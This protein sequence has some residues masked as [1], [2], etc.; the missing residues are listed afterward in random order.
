MAPTAQE[1]PSA[2]SDTAG[3]LLKNTA[4]RSNQDFTLEYIKA[5]TNIAD[6]Q[7]CLRQLELEETQVDSDLDDLLAERETLEASLDKLEVLEPQLGSLQNESKSLVK[8][9]SDTSGL[10]EGISAKVRQLDLEQSRVQ[11]A[12]KHVEDIQELKFCISGVQRAME[13]ADYE[14]AARHM[15]KA[16]GFDKTILE[17]SFAE[18][19]VPS[20]SNPE[21]P[22]VMLANAK[23]KLMEIISTEFESAVQRQSEEDI[24]RYFK[25]FPL[26]GEEQVGL[27]K[28]S[29]FVC[30]IVSGKAQASL[31]VPPKSPTFYADTLIRLF[32]SIA[33]II[34]QHQPVVEK[35]Y[36]PGK[37][38]R[39]I[40]RLQE[41]SDS[42]GQKILD[43]FEEEREISRKYFSL[44]DRKKVAEIKS[45]REPKRTNLQSTG[46][47]RSLTP[48][49]GAASSQQI[50]S[51]PEVI[52]PRELDINLNEMVLISQRS[53][54][55]NRFLE[56]RAK[57]CAAIVNT[58]APRYSPG[59][60]FVL[61]PISNNRVWYQ[62]EIEHLEKD[63]QA[64]VIGQWTNLCQESGLLRA[65]GLSRK[66]E[67]IIDHYLALEEFF[68]RRSVD[69]A[70]KIDEY[71]F[72]SQTSSCVDDVFYI[73]KKTILRAV[74]TSNV[75]CLAAMINFIKNTLEMD[76]I[77]VF[78]KNMGSVFS[79]GDTKEARFQYMILLNNV[80]VSIDYLE[81]LTSEIEHE[82]VKTIASLSENAL[83]KAKA[84]LSGLTG[85]SAKFK[86]ILSLGIEELFER[87]LKPRLRPLLQDS[88]KDIKYV[89]TDEEYA[90][91]EALNNF[92]HRFMSGLDSLIEPFKATLTEDNYN[93]VIANAVT[94]LT[95]T[96]EKIIFQT[97]FNKMGA[98]RFDKDL[99]S[100]GFYM[101]SLTSFP[102]REKLTR[103]NQMAMLL[104]LEELDDLQEIWGNNSGAITWRLTDTEVRRILSSR[105][106]PE[107]SNGLYQI[108]VEKFRSS[109]R[110]SQK[111]IEKE[112]ATLTN[113]VSDI[114][115]K[116]A[117]GDLDPKQVEVALEVIVNRLS[118]LKRKLKDTRAEE[119]LYSQRTKARLQHLQDFTTINSLDS[120]DFARWSR[121]RLNRILI[122]YMLRDGFRESASLLAKSE[123]IEDLVDIELFVQS[124]K[125]EQAL[126]RQSCTECLQWCKENSSNL[127][128]IK[129]T[130]EFSLRMQEFIELAR[131]RRSQEAIAYAQKHLTPWQET[132]LTEISHVMALLAFPPETKC[133]PY[134][135]LYDQS[136][137]NDLISQFRSNNFALQFFTPE[138][139]LNVTL[140]AGLSALKTPM[141]YQPDHR[142]INCP[143][144]DPQTLGALATDLPLSHHF[145]SSIVC[146]ISGEIMNED[147]LPMAL[148]NGYVYSYNALMEMAS[149]NNGK[150]TCPRTG[151]VYDISQMKKV[152]IS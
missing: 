87:T 63:D 81:K 67:E 125:V 118:T 116:S 119:V 123:Q 89:V 17:G 83:A 45:F 30:N 28:Y 91:Q 145:N 133:H 107:H 80:N 22:T 143:V 121:V 151:I 60:I 31:A 12:I 78:L 110:V 16:L 34:D 2:L 8:I 27:D 69:K 140:Q 139:L 38:L 5:L 1:T 135:R 13:Q 66:V 98:I 71:D 21:Y 61:T 10:A 85:S 75:D 152:F 3:G 92:V 57:V 111:H 136:R 33:V 109:L 88:Y 59:E 126:V 41:E 40:Q 44:D 51:V 35:Y 146:R 64:A 84:V 58:F 147:N 95:R 148:P 6:V 47:V 100:V 90:E 103:L 149:L 108:P 62:S 120:D 32:E 53:Q 52:D 68:L 134:K 144:C 48:Q 128:K 36:G 115:K 117:Q 7:E 43:A 18:I 106:T 105:L 97:K 72:G 93:Q 46:P 138:P 70:M 54:L 56:S 114:S 74:Y 104:D 29:R 101:I 14:D 9:I 129:S 15:H 25:L 4:V 150:I 132:H 77:S 96:W 39:V 137:W 141:C 142:N 131:E 113:S 124:A 122:D 24:T 55:Y 79:S 37:M 127:K 23:T 49:P 11:L 20:A 19:F 94:N 76:Y 99:R 82:C 50:S 65:S 86:Q 42:R 102:L 73:L 26:L 112:I 130:L